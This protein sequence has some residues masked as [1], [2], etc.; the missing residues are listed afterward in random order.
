M[1]I[2]EIIKYYRTDSNMTQK[3]LAEISGISE[4]AIRKYEKGERVPKVA[5]IQKIADALNVSAL[6]F[7]EPKDFANEVD[8][9]NHTGLE[10]IIISEVSSWIEKY[11]SFMSNESEAQLLLIEILDNLKTISQLNNEKKEY[12]LMK[13]ICDFIHFTLSENNIKRSNDN[14]YR[15]IKKEGE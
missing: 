14:A 7:L 13:S 5:Q 10:R 12:E 11:I 2:G 15:A 6:M 8:K 3:T 4:S 1:T 9:N